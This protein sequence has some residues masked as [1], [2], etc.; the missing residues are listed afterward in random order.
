MFHWE[1]WKLGNRV[2]LRTQRRRTIA[3]DLC[4][5]TAAGP[6]LPMVEMHPLLHQARTC[7]L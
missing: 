5:A 4:T 6:S 2:R 3:T 7:T 1:H